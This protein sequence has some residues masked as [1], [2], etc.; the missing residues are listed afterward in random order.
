ML[1]EEQVIKF[2][3]IYRNHFG[4][5]ISREDALNGGI[6]LVLL[7]KRIYSPINEQEYMDLQKH[8]KKNLDN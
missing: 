3:T 7:M 2:Q 8:R 6:K 4:E 5:E 1:T